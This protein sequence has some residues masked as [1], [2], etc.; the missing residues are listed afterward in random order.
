MKLFPLTTALTAAIAISLSS[1]SSDAASSNRLV[2]LSHDLEEL[3][4]ELKTEFRSHYLHTRLLQHLNNDADKIRGEAAH[5]HR[6]AHDPTSYLRHLAVDLEELDELS[7][8]LHELVDLTDT[9]RY[10][11]VH[12]NTHHLHEL[13][14]TLTHTIHNMETEVTRLRNPHGHG[15]HGHD[16]HSGHSSPGY[17]YFN[18]TYRGIQFGNSRFSFRFR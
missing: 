16:S 14:D 7:H 4:G 11:H 9:G 6:L 15:S 2:H 10:G 1:T 3:T 18:G 8:H 17:S 13:M 5:I 12:G